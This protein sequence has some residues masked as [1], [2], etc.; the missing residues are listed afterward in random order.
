MKKKSIILIVLARRIGLDG[1]R[2]GNRQ[3]YIQDLQN[4][5]RK[6]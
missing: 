2:P 5:R 4:R 1:K 6:Y 3:D